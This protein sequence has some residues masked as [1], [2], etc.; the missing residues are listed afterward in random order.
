MAPEPCR[1]RTLRYH[2]TGRLPWHSV[3]RLPCNTTADTNTKKGKLNFI[4]C[5][6]GRLQDGHSAEMRLHLGGGPMRSIARNAIPLGIG[7]KPTSNA[8]VCKPFRVAHYLECASNG[9]SVIPNTK[10]SKAIFL[11]FF[12][13]ILVPFLRNTVEW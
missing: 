1:P 11:V 10:W 13:F 7:L 9:S 2:S 12:S 6:N 8:G 3:K 4:S 5:G